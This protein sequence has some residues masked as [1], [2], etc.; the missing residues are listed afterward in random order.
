M[1]ELTLELFE[2]RPDRRWYWMAMA[3]SLAWHRLKDRR[4]ALHMADALYRLAP[5]TA[6]DWARL[7]KLYLLRSNNEL[8]AAVFLAK[9]ALSEGRFKDPAEQ[10]VLLDFLHRLESQQERRP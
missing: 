2:T 4:L 9:Q 3:T 6:P 10:Q 8:E 5:P 7:L 1:Y